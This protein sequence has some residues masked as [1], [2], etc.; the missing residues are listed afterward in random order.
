MNAFCRIIAV[1][2]VGIGVAG[3]MA[4]Q[5]DQSEAKDLLAAAPAGTRS[6]VLMMSGLNRLSAAEQT[7]NVTQGYEETVARR[8]IGSLAAAMR[9]L[10]SPMQIDI[11][12]QHNVSLAQ[13]TAL[14]QQAA[15]DVGDDGTLVWYIGTH[16]W[17][18]SFH[19]SDGSD[20]TPA[21]LAAILRASRTT[22]IRRLI[23]LFD[24]CGAGAMVK[25]LPEA[26]QGF[27]WAQAA[28][29]VSLTDA[30]SASA[31]ADLAQTAGDD[32]LPGAFAKEFDALGLSAGSV[33]HT[34]A[35]SLALSEQGPV[36]REALL[37][38]P[39]TQ[40]QTTYGM[41]FTTSMLSAVETLK[42]RASSPETPPPSIREFLDLTVSLIGVQMTKY[43][44]PEDD[45]E[46]NGRPAH[47]KAVY[48]AWP[49]ND[50]LNEPLIAPG[51]AL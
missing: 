23:M 17:N 33:T 13:L 29:G 46:E 34:G 37:F 11:R 40:Q 42:A 16:G 26:A 49:N 9:S 47:Q 36:F 45:R 6:V 4:R 7:A 35:T 8:T 20:V 30:Q 18:Q 48:R 28:E 31:L 32:D 12:E 41:I 39:V 5:S 38:A 27:D 15:R 43:Y 10:D 14:T 44:P 22:P 21:A 1:A 19:L 3:C 51:R 24:Y 2:L 50:F 25:K